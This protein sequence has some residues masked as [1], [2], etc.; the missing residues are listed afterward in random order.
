MAR[1][2]DG[3]AEAWG[4]ASSGGDASGVTLIDVA[5]AHHDCMS[6][7]YWPQPY[8][9]QRAHIHCTGLTVASDVGQYIVLA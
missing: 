7:L 9:P 3:T 4:G 2:N 6:A 1:K 8:W 5:S